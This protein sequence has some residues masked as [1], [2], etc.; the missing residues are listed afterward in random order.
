MM[1]F[2]VTGSVFVA[3][4]VIAGACLAAASPCVRT[5]D[6]WAR[7]ASWP[8]QPSSQ[9]CPAS[10]S[11]KAAVASSVTWGEALTAPAGSDAWSRLASQWVA[12][13]LNSAQLSSSGAAPTG[14]DALPPV[15]HN[16]MLDARAMLTAH[17]GDRASIRKERA[18]ALAARLEK[19]N[20]GADGHAA[21]LDR[22]KRADVVS[23]VNG[24]GND[25]VNARDARD[26]RDTDAHKS[27][28]DWSDSSSSDD[29]ESWDDSSSSYDDDD[30]YSSSG[31]GGGKKYG[32]GYHYHF[33]DPHHVL[34]WYAVIGGTVLLFIGLGV[35]WGTG[36]WRSYYRRR[37]ARWR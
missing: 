1:R 17:C 16:V 36:G 12:A 32:Y 26:A 37:N 25:G 30:E 22:Q 15:V 14:G 6:S 24:G 5:H 2:S 28:R 33:H 9:L 3:V 23:K 18:A 7:R 13:Q 34:V 4:A 21:C 31:G 8:V 10:S 27:K 35:W 11:G 20:S 19:Y 29:D